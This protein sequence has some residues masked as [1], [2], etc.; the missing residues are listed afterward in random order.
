[1]A[2]IIDFKK[3]AKDSTGKDLPPTEQSQTVAAV[4]PFVIPVKNTGDTQL[5]PRLDRAFAY[6][7]D[8]R[9]LHRH[10]QIFFIAS[11]VVK[12]G[13]YEAELFKHNGISKLAE[14]ALDLFDKNL[15]AK[16]IFGRKNITNSDPAYLAIMASAPPTADELDKIFALINQTE[17][18]KHVQMFLDTHQRDYENIKFGSERKTKF[19]LDVIK[20]KIGMLKDEPPQCLELES[21][22]VQIGTVRWKQKA[23]KLKGPDSVA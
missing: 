7:A 13:C 15:K 12:S 9:R 20:Y 22:V 5:S 6:V 11:E 8:I 16:L 2:N 23:Q 4:V 19:V 3:V 14:K 17:P 18:C 1:M 21:T 10:A